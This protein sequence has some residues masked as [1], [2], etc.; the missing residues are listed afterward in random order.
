VAARPGRRRRALQPLQ[1]GAFAD[2]SS[3]QQA[4]QER[5]VECLPLVLVDG[6]IVAEGTYPARETLAALAGIVVQKPAA[7]KSCCPPKAAGEPKCC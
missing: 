7:A 4:L 6:R 2:A 3:V 1:P 5:G